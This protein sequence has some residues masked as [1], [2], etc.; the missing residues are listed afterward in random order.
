VP[1]LFA[2]PAEIFGGTFGCNMPAEVKK[3]KID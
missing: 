2:V 1:R 3:K